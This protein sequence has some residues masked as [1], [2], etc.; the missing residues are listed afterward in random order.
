LRSPEFP[1]QLP[2]LQR[3][4]KGNFRALIGA[5]FELFPTFTR[6]SSPLDIFVNSQCDEAPLVQLFI[7]MI[8]H[9]AMHQHPSRLGDGSDSPLLRKLTTSVHPIEALGESAMNWFQK[10]GAG[11]YF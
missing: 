9:L 7:V 11:Q 2:L 8:R 5:M 10:L 4:Q 3:P 6:G 1:Q